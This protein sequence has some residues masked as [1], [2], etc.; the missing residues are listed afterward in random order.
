MVLKRPST[1]CLVWLAILAP[2][3]HGDVERISIRLLP[4]NY[5]HPR[6][7]P[8]FTCGVQEIDPTRHLAELSRAYIL[9]QLNN[10]GDPDLAYRTKVLDMAFLATTGAFHMMD[11]PC[12]ANCSG[13][14]SLVLVPPTGSCY[15]GIFA[16]AVALGK[17][18]IVVYL[19]ASL[20]V[21]VLAKFESEAEKLKGLF[22]GE[23]PRMC[24]IQ[25]YMEPIIAESRVQTLT[26]IFNFLFLQPERQLGDLGRS[27]VTTEENELSLVFSGVFDYKPATHNFEVKNDTVLEGTGFCETNI[28]RADGGKVG[29]AFVKTTLGTT[30]LSDLVPYDGPVVFSSEETTA[31]F[32][33]PIKT[34]NLQEE[35][36]T[37]SVTLETVSKRRKRS[38]GYLKSR[39]GTGGGGVKTGSS[40]GSKNEQTKQIAIENSPTKEDNTVVWGRAAKPTLHFH[41]TSERG[42]PIVS[43][44]AERK[45]TYVDYVVEMYT[46]DAP[47]F[48]IPARKDIDTFCTVEDRARELET[49]FFPCFLQD[50]LLSRGEELP[51]WKPEQR[52]DLYRKT[53]IN[54]MNTNFKIWVSD[55]WE[56]LNI[57]TGTIS[58]ILKRHEKIKSQNFLSFSQ[59]EGESTY[60]NNAGFIG[61][62]IGLEVLNED[63]DKYNMLESNRLCSA[64]DIHHLNTNDGDGD[65]ER[66]ALFPVGICFQVVEYTRTPDDRDTGD[67]VHILRLLEIP[68]P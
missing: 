41:Y 21:N 18:H 46:L 9:K 11:S 20:P 62:E 2:S 14:F 29:L 68:C 49:Q 22:N 8:G 58:S 1:W 48:R 56:P 37:F 67:P 4:R 25:T 12:E 47:V 30:N 50:I 40:G 51:G 60:L 45:Q 7:Q 19:G 57:N 17:G 28:T 63:R 33:I 53:D 5:T 31:S 52:K 32:F 36:E 13:L 42:T 24:S 35:D 34:D 39:T 3:C 64:R 54:K 66:E 10:T 15:E 43:V 23:M 6:D 27:C 38:P 26:T 16:D 59:R 65:G 55:K 61:R 44:S